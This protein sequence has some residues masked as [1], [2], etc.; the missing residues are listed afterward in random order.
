MRVSRDE[1][2][3]G[4]FGGQKHLRHMKAASAYMLMYVHRDTV[5][6]CRGTN[7]LLVTFSCYAHTLIRALRILTHTLLWR[8]FVVVQCTYT[9]S[10]DVYLHRYAHI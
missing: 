2:T 5:E 7:V 4:T 10:C 3:K 8:S 1:A 9:R 6:V